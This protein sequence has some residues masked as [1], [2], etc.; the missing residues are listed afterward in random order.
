M[1]A[2]GT[3]GTQFGPYR[4]DQ[5][6][7]RGG[8]GEVFRAYHVEQDRVVALKLLLEELGDDEEFRKRFLR[9]SQVTA[10]LTDPH[11]IPIHNWG[12]IDGRLYLDMRYVEGEDLGVLLDRAGALSPADTVTIIAQVARA[13]DAAHRAG[14]VHRDV[15]PSNVLLSRDEAGGSV[16]AYLVDF[17]IARMASGSPSTQL[18]RAGTTV[19]SLD[20]MA[21]ERFLEQPV[22]G[23]TDVYALGCLLYEC[24]TAERPFPLDG[25]APRMSAHLSS[26][27]PRPSQRRPGVPAALD[28]VVA[29]GMA[30]SPGER[31][32]TAGDLA[33]AARRALAGSAPASSYPIS[34]APLPPGRPA[35]PT[36]ANPN[37]PTTLPAH[38]PTPANQN[39]PTM[40]PAH[41]PGSPRVPTDPPNPPGPAAHESPLGEPSWSQPSWQTGP[42]TSDAPGGRPWL[43][44][45]VVLVVLA[46]LVLA[47][48]LL[49]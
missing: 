9:E 25:M 13:L 37:M 27:P 22:D 26:P 46:L 14:L 44:L 40:L 16:F 19:G 5:L 49:S 4:L 33:S 7:G 15:K 28:E 29:T 2:P 35:S 30:K 3:A 45:G 18:T 17:G 11:V 43:L 41:R 42:G 38:R 21:P 10:R 24:L 48:Y 6:L 23:R 47:G 32:A 12:I 36:P 34:G 31:F 8:M 20:Y 39:M 1:D